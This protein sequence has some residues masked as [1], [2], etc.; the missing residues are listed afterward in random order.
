MIELTVSRLNKRFGGNHVLKDVSFEVNGA[1]MIGLIGPNGAGKT[2]LTNV[3]DGAIKPNSG[4]VYLNGTRIDQLP[5]FEVAK[6]GL[7]RTFQIT[8]SFRRMTVLEN[9]YVPALALGKSHKGDDVKEQAMEVLEFLTMAH[10]RNEY[11]RALSG[12]QQKL[13]EL[14]RLLML[15]PDI[16]IL[17]EPFAGV[18]PKLMEVIY[19]YIRRVNERGK[20]MIIISHQMDSIFAL[21]K[22]LLV[23]DYGDLIADDTPENVK[24][25]P[26]VIEAYLGTTEDRTGTGERDD[27]T[28][29][30]HV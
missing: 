7:G 5:S 1:E 22:R 17:D 14:G 25:D 10:L 19:E 8:R 12:G 27:E 3:L 26:V 18:H 6:V 15:D 21:C 9:L 2:T 29:P 13:L 16:I 4:T 23:L 11:A 30:A 24:N 28:G 20:A